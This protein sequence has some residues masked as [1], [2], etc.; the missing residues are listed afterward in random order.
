[1][2][3]EE[4]LDLMRVIDKKYVEEAEEIKNSNKTIVFKWGMR[5]AC[6]STIVSV[7]CGVIILNN[8]NPDNEHKLVANNVKSTE[9]KTVINV[10]EETTIADNSPIK[11]SDLN[12]ARGEDNNIELSYG[13]S[14]L[15]ISSFKEE[16]LKEM[17]CNMI[18]EGTIT[19][20]RSKTYKYDI[21]SDK[22]EQNGVLHNTAETV[23][24][25]IQVSKTWYGDD[26]SGK[27]IT[28][29]DENY[30]LDSIFKLKKGMKFVI[31]LYVYGNNMMYSKDDD[32]SAGE[33][34]RESKYSTIYPYQPQIAVTEDEGYIV[35]EH[36]DTLVDLNARK[37]IFD[38]EADDKALSEM[39]YIDKTIFIKQMKKLVD[40]IK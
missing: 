36:W 2:K 33:S 15:D 10:V 14:S 35:S 39:Y 20:V 23:I 16:L 6:V 22:F 5:V 18:I 7:F 3:G 9:N 27:T 29:E 34:K 17:K 11:Y 31:P 13:M 37:I 32:F 25:D 28:V 38:D 12:L 40:K 19:D 30:C 26:V 1:M 21:K 24:Y 4:L 8:R